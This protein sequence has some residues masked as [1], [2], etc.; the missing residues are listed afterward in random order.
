M[1]VCVQNTKGC[2]CGV[3]NHKVMYI[4]AGDLVGSLTQLTKPFVVKMF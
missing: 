4:A 3:H 2:M 1:C